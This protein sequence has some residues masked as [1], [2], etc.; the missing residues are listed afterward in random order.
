MRKKT[1]LITILILLVFYVNAQQTIDI[2]YYNATY[3]QSSDFDR[4]QSARTARKLPT[5][6]TLNGYLVVYNEDLG[7]FNQHPQN[8]IEQLNAQKKFSRD[9]WRIPTPEELSIM[10]ANASTLGL[11]SG[12]YMCTKHANG[13]LRPV[14]TSGDYLSNNVVR[15]NNIYWA[16]SNFG[17]TGRTNAGQPLSYQ[18]ALNNAPSGYRLPTE[19]EALSLIHSGVVRFGSVTTG[20][21]LFLPFTEEKTTEWS[22]SSYYYQ[23]GEYWVQ[24]GKVLYFEKVIHEYGFNQSETSYEKPQVKSTTSTRCYVRY[25]LDK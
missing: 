11:G 2:S 4:T 24:G 10:E 19:E 13:Y 22:T 14:S 21:S 15:I 5:P 17:T 6:I 20:N 16:K 8:V 23:R 1:T 12:I 9:N 25:V 7:Y 3:R 18:E